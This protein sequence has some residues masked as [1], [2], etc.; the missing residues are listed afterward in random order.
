MCLWHLQCVP[1][2]LGEGTQVVPLVTDGLAAGVD[3]SSIM[4]VKLTEVDDSIVTINHV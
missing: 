3:C 4:E 2:L 1:P